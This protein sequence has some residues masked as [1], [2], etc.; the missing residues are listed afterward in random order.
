MT[1]NRAVIRKLAKSPSV[2]GGTRALAA[3]VAATA[4]GI[5]PEG[6][7]DVVETVINVNGMNRTAFEVVNTADDAAKVEFG[8]SGAGKSGRSGLRPLG[9]A[10]RLHQG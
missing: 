2:A 10:A 6:K 8:Q 9:R 3:K 5:D 4:K 7:F 1:G